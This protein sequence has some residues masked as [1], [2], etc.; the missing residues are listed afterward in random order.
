MVQAR[1]AEAISDKIL[2]GHSLWNDLS[3]VL[4]AI[5]FVPGKLLLISRDVVLT[6]LGLRHSASATRDVALY[7]PFRNALRTGQQVVGL[8]MLMWHVRPS[9]F[10]YF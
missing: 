5:F 2:I 3:G 4:Q 8:R 6:V 1:I 7:Q 10:F 9:L